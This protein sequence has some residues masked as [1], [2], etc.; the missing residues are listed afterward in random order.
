MEVPQIIMLT[1]RTVLVVAAV[2][3]V[4]LAGF[5]VGYA[6]RMNEERNVTFTRP[7]GE[8]HRNAMEGQ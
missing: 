3:F 5:F 4:F 1:V 6:A 2:L 7:Y 8:D